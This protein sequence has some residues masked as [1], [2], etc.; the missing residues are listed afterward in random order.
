MAP[1][2]TKDYYVIV[3]FDMR[4]EV[5]GILSMPNLGDILDP[6]Y[7]WEALAVLGNCVAFVVF[8]FQ[9]TDK[10]FIFG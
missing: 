10:S 4:N 7:V 6:A 8:D 5:F 1:S 2:I 9:L 3:S